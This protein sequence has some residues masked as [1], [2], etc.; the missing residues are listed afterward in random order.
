[1]RRHLLFA[2]LGVVSFIVVSIFY[3][4]SAVGQKDSHWQMLARIQD[5]KQAEVA[6]EKDL[7]RSRSF[8]D[9]NYDALVK[10]SSVQLRTCQ[11]M[12][13]LEGTLERE[14]KSDL[15]KYCDSLSQVSNL[16]EAFKGKNALYRNSIYFL[17]ARALSQSMPKDSDLPVTLYSLAYAIVGDDEAKTK[18]ALEADRLK[19]RKNFEE[20][21]RHAEILLVAKAETDNLI[22]KVA[23]ADSKNLLEA[24]RAEYI[25]EYEAKETLAKRYQK[26][27]YAISF[28]LLLSTIFSL[29]RLLQSARALTD[30]N[31][32]L[33]EKIHEAQE[34]SRAKSEFLANISHELRT[35]MHGILS[36]SQ[37]GSEAALRDG[38]GSLRDHFE[39]IRDSA[40]RLMRLLNDLLDLSKLEAGRMSY[41]MAENDFRSIWGVVRSELHILAEKRGLSLVYEESCEAGVGVFDGHRITQVVSNLVS[42]AIKFSFVNQVISTKVD[43]AG[44]CFTVSVANYGVGIPI[45]ELE[46]IFDKFTQSSRTKTKAGGTGLGLAICREIVIQHG[47][48]IWAESG[49]SGE[50]KFIFQIPIAPKANAI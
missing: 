16:V 46:T 35:P 48:R 37:I 14:L 29:R 36:F 31:C 33:E 32:Q 19:S 42:N 45:A 13:E 41:E 21:L 7:L 25:A 39:E 1:M 23:G 3:F 11:S 9:L 40:T 34:A 2:A 30:A 44:D 6:L 20:L 8:M 26:A 18:L 10:D 38:M 17:R 28:L 5:G 15:R 50:T 27:L 12:L 47:G 4:R 22:E 43:R 49:S 24:F